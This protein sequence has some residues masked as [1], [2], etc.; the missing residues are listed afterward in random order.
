MNEQK[1]TKPSLFLI[2]ILGLLTAFGPFSIDMYLPALPEIS[3]DFDTTTSN[4][5]LTLTLFM[6]GLAIGQVFVGPL[7]DFIGR[8]KPLMVALIVYTIASVLCVFA[9]NIYI[10]MALRFIQGF[11][12]GAGAVISR[13]ISSDLYKGKALTKFLAILMLVNGVA[14]I[15]APVLGGV[16]LSFSTWKM[17]FILLTVFGLIMF[18]LSSI[19][20]T[21]SLP[22][23]K[24]SSG[25]I[26]EVLN[27]FK[28]LLQSPKFLL[29]LFIQGCT[30]ALLFSYI[31]ASSFIT[32][33]VYHISPLAFSW[34]FAF[35]GL[36]LILSGQVINKLVDYYDEHLLMRLFGMIQIVGVVIVSITL[37]NGWPLWLLIIG[38]FILVSPVSAIGTTGFSIA[39]ANNKGGA[40]SAA[41]LLG[42]SQFLF[43]GLVS[44]LV[45]IRGE[46]DVFPYVFTIIIVSIL[47]IILYF[48]NS[49]VF[50]TT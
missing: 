47:L 32:Q 27:D 12:G 33:S 14:P 16:I 19:K 7:S 17:V 35:N 42:L 2:V 48:I 13:A 11:T 36:G 1:M 43:G 37:I 8:K 50:R 9:P 38:F 40:G 20:L 22:E 3:H 21:E 15:L 44:P 10:M 25:R 39:M 24:R 45:G 29:P 31:S 5:Q 49:R 26:S 18:S 46:Q 28:N 6:I 4:T 41:S 23:E 34:M 30:Y